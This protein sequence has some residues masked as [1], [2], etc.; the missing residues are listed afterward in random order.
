MLT[1]TVFRDRKLWRYIYSKLH[2]NGTWKQK[3]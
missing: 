2:R 1:V 3:I